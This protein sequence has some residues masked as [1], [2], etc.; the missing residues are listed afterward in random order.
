MARGHFIDRRLPRASDTV[1]SLYDVLASLPTLLR[2]RGVNAYHSGVTV[3]S[4]KS[5]PFPAHLAFFHFTPV[6]DRSALW[7]FPMPDEQKSSQPHSHFA[8]RQY[9][10]KDLTTITQQSQLL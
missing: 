4:G 3:A 2:L 6:S 10:P 5:A 9:R 7:L 8:L 1:L